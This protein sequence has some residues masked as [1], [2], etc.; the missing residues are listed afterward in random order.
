MEK[1]SIQIAFKLVSTQVV[2]INYHVIEILNRGISEKLDLSIGHNVLFS[3]EQE[4]NFIVEFFAK[5]KNKKK[6]I[7][8]NVKYI[9]FFQTRE[10]ITEDFRNSNFI[11]INAPAI[12][13]PY[14]R[15]FISTLTINAGI[16]PIILPTFNF[17]K[18][19]PKGEK[20]K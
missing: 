7:E 5:L 8:I 2:D 20:E 19:K 6:T 17:S 4:N 1:P 3:P 12:A 9:A 15:S 16:D 18:A 14:L 11:H 13:F 10:K